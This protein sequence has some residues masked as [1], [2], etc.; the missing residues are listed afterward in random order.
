MVSD[1]RHEAAAGSREAITSGVMSF[2]DHL[3]ELRIHCIRGLAGL[4]IAT[5]L[6]LFFATDII[7]I[8]LRPALII[9]DVHGQ[10]PEIQALSP[11]DAFVGYLKIA[12]LA[13]VIIAMPWILLQIWHF[14]SVGLY[15]HEQ[16]FFRL[17]APS[18]LG[19]FVAGVVFMF[20]I[21]MPLVLNFFVMFGESIE[22]DDLTP[23]FVMKMLG[24]VP[25]AGDEDL[26]IPPVESSVITVDRNPENPPVG[27]AWVN[28]T[29]KLYCVQT[30]NGILSIPMNPEK[31]VFALRNQ[32]AFD[33]YISFV[34]MMSLAFGIAFE[35]PLVILFLT[36]LKIVSV[37]ELG[38]AR[39][40]VI[41]GIFAAAAF[42][43]P[44]DVLSQ[45]LLALPMLLLFEGALVVSRYL[46][47]RKG[48]GKT[49]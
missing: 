10:R 45:I 6:S 1:E 39:R 9:L 33:R 26:V 43:T 38:K 49:A 22:V 35:L 28:T 34:L 19:L 46:D 12:F 21:V 48:V 14:V 29:R 5:V 18:S 3:E 20:Y 15:K 17:V 23:G 7:A 2:G 37:E 8:I 16:R 11:P 36:G 27:A 25:D 42:L 4:A 30:E 24:N 31:N 40:Y 44:P 41:V 47:R 32:F 13:G